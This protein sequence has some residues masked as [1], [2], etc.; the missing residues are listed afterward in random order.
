MHA[1]Y[2]GI[3]VSWQERHSN[4][5]SKYQ[6][7]QY[8]TNGTDFV[9]KDVISY[10]VTDNSYVLYSANL[11][12][13]AGVANNPQFAFRVVAE[14]ESTAITNANNNYVGT[15]TY[16]GGPSGGTIRYDLVTVYGNPYSGT[17]ASP[18]T[19]SNIVNNL[20]GTV[21][22]SYGGGSGTQFILLKS[23]SLSLA[24]DAWTP[25]ATNSATPGIY[26]VLT[27]GTDEPCYFII[28]SK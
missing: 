5:A 2:D 14:W 27:V 1:G 18:T 20:N 21:S 9:D 15:T 4:T 8:T 28:K 12:G 25:V 16:G 26:P 3:F 24:R 22:I 7:F 23:S 10:T 6:R 11:S 13:I 17:T 19:I